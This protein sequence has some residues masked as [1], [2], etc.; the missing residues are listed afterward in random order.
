[1]DKKLDIFEKAADLVEGKYY[2]KL[3]AST[4]LSQG[5]NYY[6]AEID[7]V[8]ELGDFWRFNCY[9]RRQMED[10]NFA[11]S[12]TDSY[13]NVLRWVN[14]DGIVAA[15]TPFNFTAG[16]N[17]ATV[18]LFTGNSTIWKPSDY[19]VLSN[20]IVYEILLDWNALVEQFSFVP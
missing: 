9:Y 19:S 20:Y 8:C 6:Q 11:I 15:I 2:N 10:S 18:P 5:K 16:G 1:M 4:M 17:L 7:A 3:L 13:N 14:L 12:Q